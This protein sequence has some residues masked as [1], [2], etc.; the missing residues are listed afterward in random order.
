MGLYPLKAQFKDG[1]DTLFVCECA[2]MAT[3]REH[4]RACEDLS[5]T[6]VAGE[7]NETNG[8]HETHNRRARCRGRVCMRQGGTQ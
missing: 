7:T 6:T 5:G 2:G 4:L 3:A 1:T 8:T